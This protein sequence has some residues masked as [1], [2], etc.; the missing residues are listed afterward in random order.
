MGGGLLATVAQVRGSCRM[1]EALCGGLHSSPLSTLQ[2]FA[3]GTGSAIAHRAVGAAVGAMTGGSSS[4]PAAAPA[5]PPAAAAAPA[6]TSHCDSYSRDFQR[7]LREN[8]SD[9]GSCQMY[10]DSFDN[11]T[12]SA[13]MQ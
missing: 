12:A 7:C 4:E 6:S 9:I 2:G 11:C 8:K 13:R 1:R 3:F 10:M 5:A